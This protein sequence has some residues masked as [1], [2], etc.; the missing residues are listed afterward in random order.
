MDGFYRLVGESTA[1]QANQVDASI[2]DR[3]LT[4]NDIRWDVLTRARSTLHGRTDGTD[5]L[6][7]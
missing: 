6:Q 7:K 1:A 2:A 5:R 4:G 3:L